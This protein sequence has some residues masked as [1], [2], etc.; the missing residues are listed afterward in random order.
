M[1]GKVGKIVIYML[2]AMIIIFALLQMA[3]LGSLGETLILMI[4]II[5]GFVVAMAA[6]G[7]IGNILSGFMLNAFRP[8]KMGDRVMFGELVGDVVDTN[9]AFVQIR[10][11][12]NELVNVPNN[13][14]IADK[15]VNFSA[16]GAFALTVETSIGYEVPSTL[17]KKL[18]LEATRETKDIVDDPR[19]YVLMTKMGDYAINYKLRAYTTNAKAMMQIKS[20]LQESIHEEF[21]S[22]GIEILSPWYLVRRDEKRPSVKRVTDSW[23]TSIKDEE[24]VYEKETSENIGGGFSLMEKSISETSLGKPPAQPQSQ[25]KPTLAHPIKTEKASGTKPS[26]Q[27]QM[28]KAIQPKKSE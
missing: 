21:Y 5:I 2:G 26:A 11:L 3:G 9:L 23:E 22:H 24:K 14:V 6:T 25:S 19:P 13:T 27:S 1:A 28:A 8:Y 20:R 15:I 17:V 18:L 7:S 12:N 4:S 16:S 10:T